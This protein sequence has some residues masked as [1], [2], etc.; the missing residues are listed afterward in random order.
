[1]SKY[2]NLGINYLFIPFTFS[3]TAGHSTI[4]LRKYFMRHA[5][6]FFIVSSFTI[7]YILEFPPFQSN[8]NIDI[9]Q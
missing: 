9:Q 2:V 4:T 8:E 6:I 1:M 7:V 3:R 5:Y